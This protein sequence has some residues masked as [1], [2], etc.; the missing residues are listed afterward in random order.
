MHSFGFGVPTKQLSAFRNGFI[1]KMPARMD[2]PL[3]PLLLTY[4]WRKIAKNAVIYT[5]PCCDLKPSV[6]RSC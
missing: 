3:V 4:N 1:H 6:Q 2:F 5:D